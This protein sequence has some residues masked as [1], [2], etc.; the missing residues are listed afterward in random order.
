MG[1]GQPPPLDTLTAGDERSARRL[2]GPPLA[3][4]LSAVVAVLLLVVTVGPGLL[5]DRTSPADSPPSPTA[6]PTWADRAGGLLPIRWPVRGDLSSSRPFLA[7]ALDRVR[8]ERPSAGRV[9]YAGRVPGGGRLALTGTDVGRGVVSMSVQALHIPPR[10]TLRSSEIRE[11]AALLD[12][13]EVFGHAVR[14]PDGRT[15]LL[16][17]G[18]PGPLEVQVSD[19]VEYAAGGRGR[20]AWQPGSAPDGA[21]WVPL[22][23][24]ADPVAVVRVLTSGLFTTPLLVRSSPRAPAA[25]V[26]AR[27]G[28]AAGVDLPAAERR[29]AA[30]ALSAGVSTLADLSVAD[31]RVVWRGRAWGRTY[32]MVSVTRPDGVQLQALVGE[33]N[34]SWFPSG[35]RGVPTG[36]ADVLPWPLRPY[37]S[38]EPLLLLAPTGEGQ[39]RWKAPGEP[40]REIPI[41]P[42]GVVGLVGP[43]PS[44]PS[45][46]GDEITVLGPDG[47]VE[48]RSVLPGP[49][50]DDPL[51]LD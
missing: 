30:T 47:D 5:S 36:L 31:L 45:V 26:E 43:G 51:V 19:R 34:G 37:S 24:G 14:G 12:P 38:G 13:M 8:E 16:V 2:P 32:V 22:A 46:T 10:S 11:V 20:R 18:R 39:L 1:E 6:G 33:Q 17:L 28:V 48:V 27:L 50:F 42:D 9:I 29:P 35:V 40:L 49:G 4:R 7:A 15:S 3:W 23:R 41:R 44:A 25:D 21:V